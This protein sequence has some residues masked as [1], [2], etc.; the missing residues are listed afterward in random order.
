MYEVK[1]E[2]K[3]VHRHGNTKQKNMPSQILRHGDSFAGRNIKLGY[4]P[5]RETGRV[6]QMERC[7]NCGKTFFQCDCEEYE[8]DDSGDTTYLEN[9]HEQYLSAPKLRRALGAHEKSGEAHH[10]F[11]GNIVHKL[12][13]DKNGNEK[14]RFN[15]AWNGIMLNGTTAY[16]FKT[17][18]YDIIH[19]YKE[20]APHIL[21]RS[22]G[23][24]NHNVYDKKLRNFIQNNG[25]KTCEDCINYAGQIRRLIESS[26]KNC[27]D[28]M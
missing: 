14:D 2:N 13:L 19:R 7:L 6:I 23:T 20:Q 26:D 1:A 5:V 3:S 12:N 24:P 27:L 22:Q 9:T 25:I 8:P 4:C 18:E 16:N 21:H 28:E 11:P 17:K 15:E 10:I